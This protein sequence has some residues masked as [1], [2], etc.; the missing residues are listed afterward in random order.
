MSLNTYNKIKEYI[1]ESV[2][3]LV[4][5]NETPSLIYNLNNIERSI[6]SFR[7]EIKNTENIFLYFAVKANNNKEILKFLS[8]RVDGFDVEILSN[9][10]DRKSK[11]TH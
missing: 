3:K 4:D 8:E 6:S 1:N 5:K 11:S 10:V 2:L 9:V 7:K